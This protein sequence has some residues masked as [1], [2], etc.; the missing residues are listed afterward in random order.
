MI[1]DDIVAQDLQKT[2]KGFRAL[3]ERVDFF[4]SFENRWLM[5]AAKAIL[6]IRQTY[7]CDSLDRLIEFQAV[8]L[9]VKNH[10]LAKDDEDM[11][12]YRKELAQLEDKYFDN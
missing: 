12:R 10:S 2:A 5:Q 4:E 8:D 6:K 7:P 3:A 1:I 9:F 11:M